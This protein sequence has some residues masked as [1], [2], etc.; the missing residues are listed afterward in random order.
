MRRETLMSLL[1]GLLGAKGQRLQGNERVLMEGHKGL[2][3]TPSLWRRKHR[4]P[5]EGGH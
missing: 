5:G 2:R 1:S 3:Q 4:A